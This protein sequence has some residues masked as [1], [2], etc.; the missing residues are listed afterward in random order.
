MTELRRHFPAI[1]R[2]IPLSS[3]QGSARRKQ[4]HNSAEQR[5]QV[6]AAPNGASVRFRPIADISSQYAKQAAWTFW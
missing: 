2:L 3:Q 1:C 6:S 5:S 4:G